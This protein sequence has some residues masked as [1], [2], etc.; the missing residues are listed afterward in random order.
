MVAP[1]SEH[2]TTL[3][4][5]ETQIEI[6]SLRKSYVNLQRLTLTSCPQ[7]VKGYS[8]LYN[9]LCLFRKQAD[10]VKNTVGVVAVVNVTTNFLDHSSFPPFPSLSNSRRSSCALFVPCGPLHSS[11][12]KSGN[13]CQLGFPTNL[14]LKITAEE[15]MEG[16]H[17]VVQKHNQV[18][19]VL[20]R[21][22]TGNLEPRGGINKYM[23]NV[24]RGKD[25][26]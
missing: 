5:I 26:L 8:G 13:I 1:Y 22:R 6:L 4:L 15:S 21:R 23:D 14:F 17:F 16:P 11:F 25:A 18:M 10:S 19:P 24:C 9:F 20:F 2:Q 12:M 3:P 7:K